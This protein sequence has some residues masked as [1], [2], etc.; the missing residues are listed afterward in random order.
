MK[1]LAYSYIRMSTESQLK[2]DS[3]RRQTELSAE[4]AKRH[5][6][7]LV[8]DLELRDIGVSAFKGDNA[9]TGALSRFLDAIAAGKVAAGSYLLVESLDRLSRDKVTAAMRLFLSITES[10][11]NIVTLSDGQVYRGGD[12]DFIQLVQSLTIM[13]RANEE[14]RIKSQRVGAAWKNKRDHATSKKLTSMAPNWLQLSSDRTQFTV[15]EDRAAVVRRIYQM[16]SEGHGVFSITRTLNQGAVPAFGRSNGWNES[17]VEKILKNRAVLGEYQP[18]SLAEGKRRPVGDP[19]A[20]Y[21]PRVIED[22]LF[23]AVQADRRK[24]ANSG[25]GRKGEAV[26]NLFTHIATCGYCGAPMRMVDKGKGPKGGRY[27]KCSAAVRGLGCATKGWRYDAFESSFLFV[28]KE[29]DLASVLNA[30]T[31]NRAAADL[32]LRLS[33]AQEKLTRIE[34]QRERFADLAGDPTVGVDFIRDKLT[35]T[36]ADLSETA[37]LLA[38]L[39][40]ERDALRKPPEADAA[41][42]RRLIDELKGMTGTAAYDQ[43]TRLANRLRSI[44]VSLEVATEGQKP[45]LAKTKQFLEENE[46]DPI[47][48]QALIDRIAEVS[49]AAQRYNPSFKVKFADGVIRQATVT[50]KDPMKY[51]NESVIRPGGEVHVE[52]LGRS[53]YPPTKPSLADS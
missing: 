29:V 26:K 49:V 30:E 21:Y 10:G 9:A 8:D 52:V 25:G 7:Q 12:T 2:G 5:N 45:R 53:I 38:E 50:E 6:L 36:Q 41:D 51:V 20:D 48:R 32:D 39:R 24:R 15:I 27:L 3:L 46:P 40:S 13:S 28:A 11:I 22:D 42:I 34:T 47:F 35:Q 23:L 43:R 18:H 1:P 19:I 37:T 14:S 4:Y 31:A 44:V 33:A 16:A 17:Y